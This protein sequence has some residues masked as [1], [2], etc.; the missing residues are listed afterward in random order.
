MQ[1]HHHWRTLN[2]PR[3]AAG[4]GVVTHQPVGP[5]GMGHVAA[6]ASAQS[7]LGQGLRRGPAPGLAVDLFGGCDRRHEANSTT[8]DDKKIKLSLRP[9]DKGDPVVAVALARR[10]G[11][12]I[13]HVALVPTAAAGIRTGNDQFEIYFRR[14][15]TLQ[16]LPEAGPTGAAIELR[17]RGEQRLV[18]AAQW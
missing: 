1:R 14:D 15:A 13:E 9:E 17:L 16:G 8:T 11:S 3:G 6:T 5:T 12:V 4:P 7:N 10:S 18:T 2:G